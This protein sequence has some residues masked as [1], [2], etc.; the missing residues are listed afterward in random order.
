MAI[1]RWVPAGVAIATALTRSSARTVV[2]VGGD[3]H[4]GVSAEDPLRAGDVE[5]AEP[6]QPELRRGLEVAHEVRAPVT[7]ADDGD[8]D[9]FPGS[10]RCVHR[11]GSLP[12]EVMWAG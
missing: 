4:G 12:D 7:G 6:V 1:G 9:R 11:M 8:T 10:S 5:V 3:L 2:E